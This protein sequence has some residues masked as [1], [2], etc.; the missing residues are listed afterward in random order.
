MRLRIKLVSLILLFVFPSLCSSQGKNLTM[1]GIVTDAK[2]RNPIEGARVSAVGNRAVSDAVTDTDG[3][4]ILIF[5]GDVVEGERIEIHIERSGYKPYQKWESVSPPIA[6]QF[7]LVPI[8]SIPTTPKPKQTGVS[9][10]Q[11]PKP[12]EPAQS[13]PA[14][15]APPVQPP[16]QPTPGNTPTAY[17]E[18][19][20]VK[21]KVDVLE[22]DWDILTEPIRDGKGLGENQEANKTQ[23]IAGIIHVEDGILAQWAHIKPDVLKAHEDAVKRMKSTVQGDP[24]RMTPNEEMQDA[25]DFNKAIYEAEIPTRDLL[26]DGKQPNYVRFQALSNYLGK[27]IA[28]LGDY[29]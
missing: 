12:V 10:Q 24:P 8:R 21:V 27:L 11:Q 6:L 2:S 4:F 28:K 23:F 17:A 3:S 9:A 7:S 25:A 18:L 5:R 16:S 22:G 29:R 26:L 13:Q 20:A 14:P 15:T 19:E 1:S